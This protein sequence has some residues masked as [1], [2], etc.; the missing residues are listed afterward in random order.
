MN[1]D[2]R[3]T[4]ADLACR[5]LVHKKKQGRTGTG[6]RSL[7]EIIPGKNGKGKLIKGGNVRGG[8]VGK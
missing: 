6:K 2:A 7:K 1:V 8:W 5:S 4:G 3:A